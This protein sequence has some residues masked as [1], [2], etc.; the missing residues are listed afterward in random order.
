MSDASDLAA[1]RRLLAIARSDAG[2]SRKV[3]DFLLA[4]ANAGECGGFDLTELWSVDPIIRDD[5]LLALEFT[6]LHP[7][8]PDHYGLGD[9]GRALAA[10][11]H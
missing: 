2:Q 11:A 4:W 1:I 3:A 7:N 8:Y 6:A 9:A 5:M 10:E